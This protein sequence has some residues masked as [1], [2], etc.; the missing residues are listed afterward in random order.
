[1]NAAG[2]FGA[3]RRVQ[4]V[5]VFILA[6]AAAPRQALVVT[7][8]MPERKLNGSAF[9]WQANRLSTNTATSVG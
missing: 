9:A 7:V 8:A 5:G 3:G 1:M 2:P 6:E 4:H